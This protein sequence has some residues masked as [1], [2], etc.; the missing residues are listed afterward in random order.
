M[1]YVLFVYKLYYPCLFPSASDPPLINQRWLVLTLVRAG[2]TVIVRIA[3]R[4]HLGRSQRR[5]TR[6]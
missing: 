6:D 5:F 1:D 4:I 2:G 3:Q